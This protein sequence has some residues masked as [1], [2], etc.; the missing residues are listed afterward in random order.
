MSLSLDKAEPE[1]QHRAS[2][3]PGQGQ[4][5]PALTATKRLPQGWEDGGSTARSRQVHPGMCG[6]SWCSHRSHTCQ[7]PGLAAP[8]RCQPHK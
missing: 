6:R 8:C 2:S 7:Q 4:E 1:Q 3:H 5:P